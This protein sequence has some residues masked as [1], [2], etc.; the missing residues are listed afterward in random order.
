M[1]N[2]QLPSP[3]SALKPQGINMERLIVTHATVVGANSLMED[4]SVICEDGFIVDVF[5]SRILNIKAPNA[6][7]ETIDAKGKFLVPGFMDLHIHGLKGKL[8]DRGRDEF[9]AICRELP[10]YGV[11]AFLPTVLPAEDECAILTELAETKTTG[12]EVLGF[13]LEGQFLTLT[14]AI[15]GIK[16]D[17]TVPRVEAMKKALGSRKAVFAIS[18]E[19]PGMLSLLPKMCEGGLPAFIT[20]T[21]ANYEETEKAIQAGARHATHFL[22]VFPYIGDKEPGVR[23]CG[24]VEAI[25]ANKD[26]TVDFILDGEHVDPRLIKMVLACKGIDNVC[27]ITDANINAGLEPGVFKGLCNTDIVMKYPG[28]PAREYKGEGKETGILAGSGL[29]MDLAFRNAVRMLGLSIPEAV[30]MCSANPARVLGLE[31]K[32]GKIEKGFH[33]DFSLM[34]NDFSVKA[35]YIAGK[36]EFSA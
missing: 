13:F 21:G 24:T 3:L 7:A 18:P 8:I 12:T 28:G 14:G 27:L 23:G 11:S 22:N 1:S 17:Y 10:Q 25:M 32:K 9:A 20:H 15:R 5:P 36:K 2:Q 33:A 19:I 34:D 29:T 35:C 30:A 31:K 4:Y 16:P 26:A 6:E